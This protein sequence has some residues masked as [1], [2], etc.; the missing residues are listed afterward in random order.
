VAAPAARGRRDGQ[1][2]TL[3]GDGSFGQKA[4]MVYGRGSS[5][6]G[7]EREDDTASFWLLL[8]SIRRNGWTPLVCPPVTCNKHGPG[9]VLGPPT[10]AR[11]TIVRVAARAASTPACVASATVTGHDLPVSGIAAPTPNGTA[12]GDWTAVAC[13]TLA[14]TSGEVVAGGRVSLT[15]P[16]LF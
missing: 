3:N 8:K 2:H 10:H 7:G 13:D 14:A 15:R 4:S 9:S 12:A 11:M 6:Q 1:G 16:L 5:P